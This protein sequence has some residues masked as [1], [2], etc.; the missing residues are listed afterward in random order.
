VTL[1]EITLAPSNPFDAK[2][3]ETKSAADFGSLIPAADNFVPITIDPIFIEV[4]IKTVLHAGSPTLKLS[5]RFAHNET[6]ILLRLLRDLASWVAFESEELYIL[7]A[8]VPG[9]RTSYI[10][11]MASEKQTL[12]VMVYPLMQVEQ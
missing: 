9:P 4:I 10:T 7:E 11:I 2:L 6:D 8:V 1:E 5:G 12:P 3:F